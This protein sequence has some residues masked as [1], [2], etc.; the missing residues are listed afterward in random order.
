MIMKAVGEVLPKYVNNRLARHRILRPSSPFNLTYSVTNMCQSRCRTCFIWKIYKDNPELRS[1][2]LK[3][4]EIEKMFRTVGHVYFFN[5]SGGEPF[6]RRDFE[7]LVLLGCKHLTPGLIHIPT[8][9]ISP[10]LVEKKTRG[11]LQGMEAM[12]SRAALTIKPSFDGLG[13]Q[14]DRIRGVRN[15][16]P[17]VLET[18]QRLKRLKEKFPR[19]GLG[20]GTVV[21]RHNVDSLH[22]IGEFVKTVGVDSYINEIAELRSEMFNQAEDITPDR[23]SYARA[24]EYFRARV[25]EDLGR[26][27]GL[28]RLTQCFKLVYYDLVVRTME[29]K[30]Q[31]I[32]CYGGISNVHI[33]AYGDLWPCCILAEDRSMGNVKDFDF[34]FKKAWHSKRADEVRKYIRAGKCHC[35]LENQTFSNI[36]YHFPSMLKVLG[37]LLTAGS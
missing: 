14:H 32:P 21:S 3:L 25:R 24:M 37:N 27:E 8:N 7:D 19:L 35:T 13:E 33:S 5:L 1:E 4:G 29:E 12:G 23:S 6:L 31:V 2:E 9:G 16:F 20:L 10:Q 28:A 15:N 22:E 30:R 17:L 11:I 26:L 36:M 18:T 34:H